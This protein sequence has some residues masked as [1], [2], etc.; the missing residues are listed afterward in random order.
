MLFDLKAFPNIRLRSLFTDFQNN[1]FDFDAYA[2]F[3]YLRDK[4]VVAEHFFYS[5]IE[6]TQLARSKTTPKKKKQR[7]Q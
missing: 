3:Y 7:I 1:L 6:I 5:F 4:L 2:L